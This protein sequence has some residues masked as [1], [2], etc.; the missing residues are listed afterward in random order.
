M[1][2]LAL[3]TFVATSLLMAGH[4][5]AQRVII[6]PPVNPTPDLPRD[7]PEFRSIDGYGNNIYI[8]NRGQASTQLPVRNDYPGTFNIQDYSLSPRYISNE[9]SRDPGGSHN[10]HQLSD[11]FWLWGQFLD[12][13]IVQTPTAEPEERLSISVPTGDPFFDPRREGNK[14]IDFKRSAYVF[15]NGQRVQV[16]NVTAFVDGS[17]VYGS[18]SQ[19]ANALRDPQDSAKLRVSSGN[20]LP[21]IEDVPIDDGGTGRR[22]LYAAGDVRA[23]EHIGLASMHTVFVREHNRLVD[24]VR[25]QSLN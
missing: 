12:H 2:N 11:L 21:R 1:K 23:N 6:R 7:I 10:Q 13:D 8:P 15:Q 4:G 22:G 20:L 16:N 25:A 18:F 3:G 17:Q 14:S 5:F 9:I 19:T 24:I